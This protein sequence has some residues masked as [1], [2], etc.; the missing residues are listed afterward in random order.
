MPPKLAI[1]PEQSYSAKN[2]SKKNRQQT[3]YTYQIST[4]FDHVGT[5]IP[6][7][8]LEKK[9]IVIPFSLSKVDAQSK[10]KFKGLWKF[11]ATFPKNV[12]IVFVP[13]DILDR[14]NQKLVLFPQFLEKKLNS[15]EKLIQTLNTLSINDEEQTILTIKNLHSILQDKEYK[16]YF[17]SLF[18]AL[19]ENEQS[20]QIIKNY[21][22]KP[23]D[24]SC[25]APAP[26][27]IDLNILV[28][29]LNSMH[30]AC[31]RILPSLEGNTK[32]IVL[33]IKDI[34][35]FI[36]LKEELEKEAFEEAKL[37]GSQ[38]ESDIKKAFT[39]LDS[40]ETP[41]YFFM[42]WP[43]QNT[44]TEME[45][46]QDQ[47]KKYEETAN[48]SLPNFTKR[49]KR[50]HNKIE[51]FS[52]ETK[53]IMSYQYL[54][55]ECSIFFSPLTQLLKKFLE[56]KIANADLLKNSDIV[57]LYAG[58][59]SSAMRDS[60]PS[61][62]AC[63]CLK[64]HTNPELSKNRRNSISK[65]KLSDSDDS[66]HTTDEA[67]QGASSPSLLSE[68]TIE[69]PDG[70]KIKGK[71]KEGIATAVKYADE[72]LSKKTAPQPGWSFCNIL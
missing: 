57:M 26:Q 2:S 36:K 14:H 71:G 25:Q 60:I 21:L 31:K 5:I 1:A 70:F 61:E 28:N 34:T 43:F 45:F 12:T 7:T 51:Y 9:I 47:F 37:T 3:S 18:S 35:D 29:A 24:E 54:H 6:S 53:T 23:D 67:D 11:I 68:V 62:I 72:Y 58:T 69:L 40:L 20:Y 10:E 32:E 30:V 15:L 13:G 38:W 56:K 44:E 55:E 27:K 48:E 49:L 42:P 8:I 63:Y 64:H 16:N 52:N 66:N 59:I 4:K 50:C 65:D 46:S 19:H 41:N 17:D 39:E 22:K 33:K